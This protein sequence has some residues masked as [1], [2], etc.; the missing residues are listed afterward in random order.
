MARNVLRRCG[1]AGA[2]GVA[3]GAFAGGATVVGCFPDTVAPGAYAADG[4]AGDAPATGAASSSPDPATSATTGTSGS[5]AGE[6]TADGGAGAATS[7]PAGCDLSGRWIA[8]DRE[9]SSALGSIEAS[10]IWFYFELTQTGGAGTVSK[11][12]NCGQNARNISSV[13]ANVDFPKTWPALQTKVLQ[14]GREYTSTASGTKCSVSFEKRYGVIG[15]TEAYYVDPSQTMPTMSQ[16]AMGSTPGWEDWDNDGNPGYTLNVSG[17]ATG[18]VYV[19]TRSWN[20]WS[21]AIATA[22]SSFQLA[23]DWNTETDLLGYDGSSLLSE[24]TAGVRDS[25]DTLH[26]VDFAR[27]GA[28]QATGDDDAVCASIRSLATTLTPD[29]DN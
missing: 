1:V 19:A 25:D 16:E 20:A 29:A 8:T 13:G 12:L 7:A 10:H 28:T 24:T 3:C 27:L 14:T 5:G 22:A 26:F 17:L 18:Q 4:D 15:A 23:D 2:I 21:G 6:S 11:G 9:V